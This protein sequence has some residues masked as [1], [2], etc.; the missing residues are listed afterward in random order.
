MTIQFNVGVKKVGSSDFRQSK[1]GES[2]A[3][4]AS[5]NS[6]FRVV[7]GSKASTMFCTLMLD[8]L[9]FTFN[10]TL[11]AS[12]SKFRTIWLICMT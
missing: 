6:M 5:R 10:Q 7:S 8:L 9:I 3:V 4:N 2:S 11:L 1:E 12:S